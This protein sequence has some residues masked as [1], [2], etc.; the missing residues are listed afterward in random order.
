MKQLALL[1]IVLVLLGGTAAA[2][3]EFSEANELLLY[4]AQY[5]ETMRSPIQRDRS[6]RAWIGTGIGFGVNLIIIIAVL[7]A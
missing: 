2:Q 7:G 4:Q 3:D 6:R 1:G 5:Q